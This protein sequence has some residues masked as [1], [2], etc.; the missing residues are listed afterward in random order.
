MHMPT[1]A[2]GN[3]GTQEFV[4]ALIRMGLVVRGAPPPPIAPLT[5]GVSSD[6]VRVD[7]ADGPIC[8]KRAL[9]KLKVQADWQA[10][11]E[12]NRWEV[13]WMKVAASIQPTAVPRV[14]GEDVQSGTF[15]MEF[16]DPARHAVWKSRLLE[17]Y[18]DAGFAAQVGARIASIH[19]QTAHRAD[20]AAEFDTDHIFFPI[21]LEPYLAATARAQPALAAP[22]TRL[23]EITGGTKIALVHGDVSPKNILCGPQGP[24]FLDAECA[25]YGDPAFD[26]A[27]CLNHMLLKCVRRPQ[28]TAEYLACFDALAHTYLE[29]VTW[30]APAQLEARAAHLLPGL[31]IARIDGKSPVEYITAE[32]EREVVRG[33]AREFLMQP[34]DHLADLGRAWESAVAPLLQNN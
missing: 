27:F 19:A 25:W 20:L 34:T 29:G 26:L 16:L 13:A 3:G 12:R 4:A 10:P 7:L 9:P 18:A 24:I 14:L 11:V 17:G 30:E 8:L 2:A 33:I 28:S 6:I 22:L 32:R 1:N 21:R 31:L 15:A 23:I 5:G